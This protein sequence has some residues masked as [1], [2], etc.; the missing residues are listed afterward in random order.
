MSEK[1]TG[2]HQP[3][4]RWRTTGKRALTVL[5][6]SVMGFCSGI[7]LTSCDDAEFKYSNFHCNFV[8][9]NMQHQDATLASAMN[10]FAKGIF[11]RIT[12]QMKS[13]AKYFIFEN[14]NGDRSEKIFNAED[15]R[16]HSEQRIGM[17]NGLIVGYSAYDDVFFAYDN[18]CPQCFDYNALPVRNY[19]LSF[20][21]NDIVKCANCKREFALSIS[22]NGLTRYDATTTG[23]L[24]LLHVH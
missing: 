21:G 12:F 7:G 3:T 2:S 1:T 8:L 11:C 14:T 10:P 24:G 16:N 20:S 23:P 4:S 22:G 15:E 19:P 9:N 6:C 13:G 5:L 18:Q 17:N